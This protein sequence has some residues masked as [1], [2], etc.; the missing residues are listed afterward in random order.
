MEHEETARLVD[1]LTADARL[2]RFDWHNGNCAAAIDGLLALAFRIAEHDEA[3]RALARALRS[4]QP[5]PNPH[6]T[7]GL[8]G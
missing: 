5:P 8:F 1:H 6:D 2:I 3:L 7:D 4:P